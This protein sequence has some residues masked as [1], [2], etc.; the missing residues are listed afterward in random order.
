LRVVRRHYYTAIIRRLLR[1][2]VERA[3]GA[4][5]VKAQAGD[6]SPANTPAAT[7]NAPAYR[8]GIKA[9]AAICFLWCYQAAMAVEM[10]LR[11]WFCPGDLLL[12]D[13]S[14]IDDLSSTAQ[15]LRLRLPDTLVRSSARWFAARQLIFLSAGH[16]VEYG[17]IVDMDLTP[18]LHRKKGE[19]YEHMIR[20]IEKSGIPVRRINT[21]T[22]TGRGGRHD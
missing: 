9:K 17:R 22:R 21:A 7:T 12:M 3:T 20:T 15:T 4:S 16:E 2:L 18:E 13:R 11:D 19:A 5:R 6:S 8:S 10:R 14:Y 1:G